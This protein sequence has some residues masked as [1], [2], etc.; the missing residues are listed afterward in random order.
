M[1]NYVFCHLFLNIKLVSS[2]ENPKIEF[3]CWFERESTKLKDYVFN[4]NI[5]RLR[6]KNFS[7]PQQTLTKSLKFNISPQGSALTIENMEYSE[8]LNIKPT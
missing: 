7:V 1:K 2:C 5:A 4:H 8:F 6:T 3:Y